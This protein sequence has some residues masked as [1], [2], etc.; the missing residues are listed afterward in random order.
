MLLFAEPP[1]LAMNRNEYVSP[2]T[3]SILISAGKFVPVLTSSHTVSGA[4]CE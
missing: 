2:S 1:P 4:I 3:A